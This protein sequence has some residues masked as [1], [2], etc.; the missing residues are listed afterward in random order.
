MDEAIAR[1]KK[2]K[3]NGTLDRDYP[4]IAKIKQWTS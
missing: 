1:Y 2:S 4:V 3:E